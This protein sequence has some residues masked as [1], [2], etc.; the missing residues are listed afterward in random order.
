MFLKGKKIYFVSN[1]FNVYFYYFG[2]FLQISLNNSKKNAVS[3][4]TG[5]FNACPCILI[6]I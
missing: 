2:K 1:W 6:I 4:D 5:R 3:A